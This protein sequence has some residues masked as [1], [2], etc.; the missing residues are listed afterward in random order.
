MGTVRVSHKE[1]EEEEEDGEGGVFTFL[2][3]AH[4]DQWTFLDGLQELA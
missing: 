2:W 1:E 3:L 4:Y